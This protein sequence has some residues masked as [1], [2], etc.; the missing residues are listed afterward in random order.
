MESP[1][2]S[3]LAVVCGVATLGLLHCIAMAAR[4][5]TYIHD[6]RVRVNTLRNEKLKAI[7]EAAKLEDPDG[8]KN[9]KS[10][11]LSP[12][13]ASKPAGAGHAKPAHGH[14]A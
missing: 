8:L 1:I 6:L 7:Q 13:A 2:W 14:A 10:V 3:L 9:A 4:N 5:F 11:P 12:H